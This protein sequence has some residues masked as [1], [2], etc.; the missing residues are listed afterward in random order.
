MKKIPHNRAAFNF[1]HPAKAFPSTK[2]LPV[3]ASA[4]TEVGYP[5]YGKTS[6]PSRLPYP[7]W[8]WQIISS[9]SEHP[10]QLLKLCVHAFIL[11]KLHASRTTMVIPT[12]NIVSQSSLIT[13]LSALT[14]WR[15]TLPLCWAQLYQTTW[16]RVPGLTLSRH[17]PGCLGLECSLKLNSCVQCLLPGYYWFVA[18][19]P[20][21]AC[22]QLA[23]SN[24]RRPS[25]CWSLLQHQPEEH[26][27][28]VPN[29]LIPDPK[30]HVDM[31][32]LSKSCYIQYIQ[33]V[34]LQ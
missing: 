8:D 11:K 2:V 20:G 31:H 18:L 32:Q 21:M 4:A 6:T 9:S 5:M 29:Q 33:L 27:Q 3:L 17:L 13:K 7:A 1:N 14:L 24:W 23:S 10:K 34:N 15:T 22:C 19:K 30:P 28:I 16:D 26:V 12:D 25:A